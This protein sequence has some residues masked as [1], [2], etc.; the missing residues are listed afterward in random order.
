VREFGEGDGLVD[1]VDKAIP[2]SQT[3]GLLPEL[4]AEV[5]RLRPR[6]YGRY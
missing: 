6:P 3:C 1:M 2:C 4:L 5:A